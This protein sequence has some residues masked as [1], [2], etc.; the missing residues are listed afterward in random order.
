MSNT[1]VRRPSDPFTG[2]VDTPLTRDRSRWS[3]SVRPTRGNHGSSSYRRYSGDVTTSSGLS[4]RMRESIRRH[5]VAE[6]PVNPTPELNT[7]SSLADTWRHRITGRLS[8]DT[9]KLIAVDR[10]SPQRSESFTTETG[11]RPACNH[12][13]Q[14]RQQT[15]SKLSVNMILY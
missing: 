11:C 14:R 12:H 6:P 2:H 4:F 8:R 5:R 10:L 3:Y 13:N 15:V 7:H 1:V 9:D